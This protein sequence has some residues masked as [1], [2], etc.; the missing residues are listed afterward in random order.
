MALVR[1]SVNGLNAMILESH[2]GTG[3]GPAAI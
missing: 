2:S 1:G 3:P